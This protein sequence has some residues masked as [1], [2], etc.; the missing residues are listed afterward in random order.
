MQRVQLVLVHFLRVS[1]VQ[2]GG[3]HHG[4]N[5]GYKKCGAFRAISGGSF[6]GFVE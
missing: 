3:I 5:I 6:V 1:G 2:E 4:L